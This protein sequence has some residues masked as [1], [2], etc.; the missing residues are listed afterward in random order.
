MPR[1][2]RVST[3]AYKRWVPPYWEGP[4]TTAPTEDAP[5][6]QSWDND[7]L[8]GGGNHGH[9]IRN[10]LMGK[11]APD[12]GGP[13]LIH[14][15]SYEEQVL[16]GGADVHFSW[17]T[18]PD[19]PASPYFI[20]NQWPY[21]DDFSSGHFPLPMPSTDSSLEALGATAIARCRPTKPQAD[22]ATFVGELREGIPSAVGL[23]LTGQSR[24]RQARNAGDEYLN[25]EFGWKPLLRDFRSFQ[26]A[27]RNSK[28]ALDR[29][30]KGAG[31][32]IKRRYNFPTELK[33]SEESLGI[34]Y[35]VPLLHPGCYSGGPS[36]L[37]LL[38]TEKVE[39]WFSGSFIYDIPRGEDPYSKIDEMDALYGV[40]PTPE[41]LWNLAPWSWAADWVGNTG[42]VL[43]NISSISSDGLVMHHAYMMEHKTNVYEY[44]ML[45]ENTWYSHPG[46][47]SLRQRFT[48]ETKKR[49][50]ATP[51]GFGLSWDDFDQ[52]QLAILGSLGIS[53]AK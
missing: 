25:V 3:R 53:R 14:K 7:L 40:E 38:K 13:L 50:G 4:H 12:L 52:R 33:V 9:E 28:R 19:V 51:Y 35:P 36:E 17:S 30:K 18:D 20:T 10:G 49:V 22:L 23:S 1:D 47:H 16:G 37:K 15:R 45:T 34:R 29:Y 8:L 44:S 48:A 46:Q 21:R 43:A 32:L 11:G 42:D 39:R 31:V 2:H 26:N 27:Y 41:T 5:R 6:V 24:A